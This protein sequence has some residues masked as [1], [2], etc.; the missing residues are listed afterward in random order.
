MVGFVLIV[1]SLVGLDI[2]ANT[3]NTTATLNVS[4]L[5]LQPVELIINKSNITPEEDLIF[6]VGP[7]KNQDQEVLS[8]MICRLEFSPPQLGGVIIMESETDDDGLC[9][10][11][12]DLGIVEQN[13]TLIQGTTNQLSY[14]NTPEGAGTAVSRISYPNATQLS[15]NVQWL[16]DDNIDGV[17]GVVI[18]PNPDTTTPNVIP[19]DNGSGGSIISG[20]EGGGG[21]NNLT[22]TPRTGGNIL[23]GVFAIFGI[24]FMVVIGFVSIKRNKIDEDEIINAKPNK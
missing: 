12:T 10:Y 19:V 11:R 5:I 9:I 20:P 14:I 13:W 22:I 7:V 6:T 8:N 4:P 18:N 16:I 1:F 15:N 3:A 23:I 24:G 17:S 21:G 2:R